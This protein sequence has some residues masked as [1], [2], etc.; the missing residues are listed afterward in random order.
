MVHKVHG[1]KQNHHDLAQ[2]G[3]LELE[4][5][6]VDPA[7]RSQRRCAEQA[8]H[9]QQKNVNNV[10]D[11]VKMENPAVIDQRDHDHQR[12]PHQKAH[13]LSASEGRIS[14]SDEDHTDRTDDNQQKHQHEIVIFQFI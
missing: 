2:L 5:S 6:D 12:K 14:G 11:P 1:K 4:S 10:D 13:Q 8:D 3:R 7:S 9:D